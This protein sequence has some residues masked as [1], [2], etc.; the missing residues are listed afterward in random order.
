MTCKQFFLFRGQVQCPGAAGFGVGGP[1]TLWLSSTQVLRLEHS[2]IWPDLLRIA[3]VAPKKSISD[4][5][6][7]SLAV[8]ISE[9]LSLAPVSFLPSLIFHSLNTCAFIDLI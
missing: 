9:V 6:L 3:R 1:T 7:L 5:F 4:T 8:V 2:T